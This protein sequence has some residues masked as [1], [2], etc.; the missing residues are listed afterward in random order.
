MTSNADKIQLELEGTGL[1]TTRF[2]TPTGKE[3]IAFD[4]TIEMGSHKGKTVLVGVS[5]PDAEYPEYPPHWLHVSPPIN[6]GKGGAV[7]QYENSRRSPMACYES[8]TGGHLGPTEYQAHEHLHQGTPAPGLER[9]MRYDVVMTPRGEPNR[10]RA[11][12]EALPARQ[13]AG[14][15]L[16]RS[17]ALLNRTEPQGGYRL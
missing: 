5:D 4:Y 13:V 2:K 8:P 14:R 6:D 16:L 15:P 10:Q 11:L 9:R 1:A 17:V 12:V 3:V 7:E